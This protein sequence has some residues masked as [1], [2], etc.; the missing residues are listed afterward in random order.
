[1]EH[2]ESIYNLIKKDLNMVSKTPLYKSKYSPFIPPTA[3]TFNI[4]NTSFPN[5]ANIG[6]DLHWH[7]GAHPIK[8]EYSTLGK[9]GGKETY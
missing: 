7:R 8:V 9:P 1:M 6:G 5:V 4:K 2:E 3:T